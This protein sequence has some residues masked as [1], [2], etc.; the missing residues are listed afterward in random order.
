MSV[1]SDVTARAISGLAAAYSVG[2]ASAFQGFAA[3]WVG[4]A[5]LD[6]AADLSSIKRRLADLLS[7]SEENLFISNDAALLSSAIIVSDMQDIQQSPTTTGI[8]L[9]TG[10]GTIAYSYKVMPQSPLPS[11]LDRSAGWG[12]LLGDEGSGY[13]IGREA[14]RAALRSR[15]AGSPPS[16]FH[17]AIAKYF[18]C[19]LVGDIIS[20]VYNPS[21]RNEM[22]PKLRIAGLCPLVFAHAFSTSP[23]S[24]NKEALG[25]VQSAAISA[26]ETV[27]VHLQNESQL[28]ASNST[29]V[30]GGTLG[31]IALFK[32]LI[33]DAL[34][35]KGH[36]FKRIVAVP[37]AAAFAVRWLASEY[38]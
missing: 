30:M 26:A 12:Y 27:A 1:I 18:D 32:T 25:I 23:A 34:H 31:Q 19:R 33:L 22:D 17:E 10:T 9:I 36:L 14:I 4:G 6:R 35:K 16:A 21:T 20:A 37:D 8:V 28:I 7:L 13:Y 5:G 15:D 2:Q 29:L 24:V 38:L 11:P 3:A